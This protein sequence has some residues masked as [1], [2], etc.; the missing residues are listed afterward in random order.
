MKN[1]GYTVNEILYNE[2]KMDEFD[3]AIRQK[4]IHMVGEI[5]KSAGLNDDSIQP[6]LRSLRF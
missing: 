6:I 3:K 4:N 5:L 2:G 1:K